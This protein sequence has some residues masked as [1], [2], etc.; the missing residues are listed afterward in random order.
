MND[1]QF[2]AEFA[3]EVSAF[4][5]ETKSF[6]GSKF[7]PNLLL[8][9]VWVQTVANP[10]ETATIMDPAKIL[11][12]LDTLPDTWPTESRL[13]ADVQQ[14]RPDGPGAAHGRPPDVGERRPRARG[15]TRAVRRRD[16]ALGPEVDDAEDLVARRYR[17]EVQPHR[18]A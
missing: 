7:L 8:N 18:A 14:V 6:D 1:G 2:I 10:D 5:N 11:E 4:M 16:E 13:L 15:V 12:T 9:W 3:A 17:P